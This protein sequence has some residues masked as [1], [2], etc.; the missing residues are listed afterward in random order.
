MN[1]KT[2]TT[3]NNE[4]IIIVD[5]DLIKEY[6]SIINN[7]N[8]EK[9]D[10][11]NIKLY[12]PLGANGL[13]ILFELFPFFKKTF[14][15]TK[16]DYIIMPNEF[17]KKYYNRYGSPKL[18]V[19][20]DDEIVELKGYNSV[21]VMIDDKYYYEYNKFIGGYIEEKFSKFLL[22]LDDYKDK[23]ITVNNLLHLYNNK[24]NIGNFDEISNILNNNEYDVTTKLKNLLLYILNNNCDNILFKILIE[25]HDRGLLGLIKCYINDKNSYIKY[26]S[27]YF[28]I[29]DD[30][31]NIYNYLDRAK[32][33]FND[34]CKK[35]LE[36]F[37]KEYLL[38][39]NK[40]VIENLQNSLNIKITTDIKNS[41]EWLT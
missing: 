7:S 36:E 9:I 26:L 3:Y 4:K 37:I 1:C 39:E 29:D 28:N 12:F 24:E 23:I 34:Y 30:C 18:Y 31:Y 17:K 41:I 14:D 5:N 21:N 6:K 20:E 35:D 16:A 11:K 25:L 8:V 40:V 38:K 10:N 15:I 13:K 32:T 22:N 27:Y 19:N 2:I 33:I